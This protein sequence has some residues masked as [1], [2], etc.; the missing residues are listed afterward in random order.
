MQERKTTQQ[1]K[2]LKRAEL[3]RQHAAAHGQVG[4]RRH[5][6]TAT[7]RS[8][9]VLA[10]KNRQRRQQQ[11]KQKLSKARVAPRQPTLACASV[12]AAVAQVQAQTSRCKTWNQQNSATGACSRIA[13]TTLTAHALPR[14]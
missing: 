8:L 7:A 12:L 1:H 5:G 13:I 6:C 9:Q 10:M 3:E 4:K 11:R 2:Q 14:G